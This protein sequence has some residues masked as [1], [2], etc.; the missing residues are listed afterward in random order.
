MEV[1]D[2]ELREVVAEETAGIREVILAQAFL[3][4]ALTDEHGEHADFRDDSLQIET[5]SPRRR[6]PAAE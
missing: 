2:Q 3:G 6:S 1:L 5:P 4:L